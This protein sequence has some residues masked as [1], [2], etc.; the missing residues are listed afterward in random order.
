VLTALLD[1]DRRGTDAAAPLRRLAQRIAD[2]RQVAG[3]H[4]PIDTKAGQLL[5][6]VLGDYL[7]ARCRGGDVLTGSFNSHLLK[8]DE[9]CTQDGDDPRKRK[10]DDMWTKAIAVGEKLTVS[11]SDQLVWLWNEARQEWGA[12]PEVVAT[13][14]G[15]T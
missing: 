14:G 3:L 4:Y 1:M 7:V 8:G 15:V 13:K 12:E 10:P 2:N 9:T 11:E 6:C 5:G